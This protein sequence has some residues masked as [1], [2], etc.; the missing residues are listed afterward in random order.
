MSLESQLRDYKNQ[1]LTGE[2]LY[3]G[4]IPR[5]DYHVP[6]T[7][8]ELICKLEKLFPN[9]KSNHFSKMKRPQRWAIFH[10]EMRKRMA[11]R[12]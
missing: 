8:H 7:Q 9:E 2:R 1:L 5:I 12:V 4:I 3:Q 6:R 11:V 10:N